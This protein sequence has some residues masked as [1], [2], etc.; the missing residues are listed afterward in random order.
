MNRTHLFLLILPGILAAC[1]PI[2]DDDDGEPVVVGTSSGAVQRFGATEEAGA[3]VIWSGSIDPSNNVRIIA[4][5]SDVFVA[6]GQEVKLFDDGDAGADFWD[7]PVSFATDVIAIAGP[8]GGAIFVLTDSA[9]VAIQ[10]ADGAELWNIDLF[11]LGDPSDDALTVVDGALFL[12]GNPTNRI[13]PDTGDVTHSAAGTASISRLVGASG[14]VYVG[15]PNGVTAY[16]SSDLSQSWHHDTDGSV[17]DMVVSGGS[18][19]YAVFGG[20]G[21]LGLLTTSGNPVAQA[22]PDEVFQALALGGNLLLGAR[23]DGTLVALDEAD[24]AEVWTA[25]G[26]SDVRG[27]SL[28]SQTIFYASGGTLD[29]INLADGGHLYGPVSGNGSI[30]AAQAL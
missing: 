19:G 30:V 29:G 12:A 27:L 10:I 5:G 21:G 13:D 18:V 8:V 24:L 2:L 7:P 17:D 25:P 11:D 16:S 26:D 22:E 23:A 20:T 4:D 9:L 1:G 14:S 3:S 15:G 28:N 6:S